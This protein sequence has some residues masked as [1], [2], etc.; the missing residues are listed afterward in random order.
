MKEIE[1]IDNN[2]RKKPL[3][4]ERI[5]NLIEIYDDEVKWLIEIDGYPI[6]KRKELGY[7]NRSDLENRLEGCKMVVIILHT[8]INTPPYLSPYSKENGEYGFC[9]YIVEE[10]LKETKEN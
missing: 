9:E 1:Q 10:Y 2:R 4:E 7:G 3:T 8:L 6:K 5:N